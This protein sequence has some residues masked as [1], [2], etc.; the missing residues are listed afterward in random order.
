MTTPQQQTKEAQGPAGAR[1]GRL[2]RPR[3]LAD[4]R[5]HGVDRGE[6]CAPDRVL[7]LGFEHPA[8]RRHDRDV[9]A[10]EPL[11]PVALAEARFRPPGART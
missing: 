8:D 2:A 7:L 10:D 4:L 9:P 1:R 6:R 5:A 11:P 3:G